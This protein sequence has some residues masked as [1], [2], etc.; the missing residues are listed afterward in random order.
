MMR[1]MNSIDRHRGAQAL[2]LGGGG[3]G[4]AA[5][6]ELQE[7]R[8]RGGPGG[9]PAGTRVSGRPRRPG[10]G[11]RARGCDFGGLNPPPPARRVGPPGGQRRGLPARAPRGRSG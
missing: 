11:S 7:R 9:A 6:V 8:P 4:P 5:G 2:L 10:R 3:G 1:P